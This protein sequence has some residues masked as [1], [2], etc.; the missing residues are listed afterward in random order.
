M[1]LSGVDR[2]RVGLDGQDVSL[3]VTMF[4]LVVLVM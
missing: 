2:A 3:N 4:V 1:D